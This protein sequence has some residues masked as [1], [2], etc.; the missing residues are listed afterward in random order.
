[1]ISTDTEYQPASLLLLEAMALSE[2]TEAMDSI[3][4]VMH[5]E[6]TEMMCSDGLC[7][8]TLAAI[9]GSLAQQHYQ[10]AQEGAC[11]AAEQV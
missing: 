6:G 2:E 8:H 7:H 5:E 3:A 11:N 10:L 1:M 9:F 4:L